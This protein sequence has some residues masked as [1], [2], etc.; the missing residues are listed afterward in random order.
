[1]IQKEITS[2][3]NDDIPKNVLHGYVMKF[4]E[5]IKTFTTSLESLELNIVISS[6][7]N[8]NGK[9]IVDIFKKYNKESHVMEWG[10]E[11]DLCAI[12]CVRKF[13]GYFYKLAYGL[14][15][16]G[17]KFELHNLHSE[18]R[19][20]KANAPSLELFAEKASNHLK[21]VSLI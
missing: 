8:S 13:L 12:F 9:L 10:G 14:I 11:K 17:N 2:L 19:L 18:L 15:L 1:M 21:D 5:L 7:C 20:D 3:Q 4:N 16:K 6:I